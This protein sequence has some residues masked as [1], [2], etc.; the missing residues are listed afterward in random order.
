[1]RKEEGEE[2]GEEAQDRAQ[3]PHSASIASLPAPQR[4]AG[5]KREPE[6]LQLWCGRIP[7]LSPPSHLWGASRREMDAGS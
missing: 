7:C 6:G 5:G 1:M 3:P 2:G 4:R